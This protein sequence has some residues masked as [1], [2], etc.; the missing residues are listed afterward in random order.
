MLLDP[1]GDWAKA[2]AA[3]GACLAIV[4]DDGPSLTLAK[5]IDGLKDDPPPAGWDGAWPLEHK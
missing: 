5:R 3:F 4:P 2:E 1:Y